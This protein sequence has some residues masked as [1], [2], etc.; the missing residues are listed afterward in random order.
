MGHQLV[1]NAQL[2]FI[3]V[4]E[5][6]IVQN[7]ERDLILYRELL[8]VLHVK[9]VHMQHLKDPLYVLYAQQVN[10]L[11]QILLIV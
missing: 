6:H 5:H 7:V 10:I 9:Q 4:K 11:S 8:L 2:V 1:V 3:L